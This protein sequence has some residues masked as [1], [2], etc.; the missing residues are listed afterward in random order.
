[1]ARPLFC[2]DPCAHTRELGGRTPNKEI[3]MAVARGAKVWRGWQ[4]LREC[5]EGV[6]IVFGFREEV[7]YFT[8][9]AKRDWKSDNF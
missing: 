2:A 6:Y 4:V 7:Y 8:L 5:R 9:Y 1:M 3:R